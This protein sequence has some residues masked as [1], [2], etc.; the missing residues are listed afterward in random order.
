MI[1]NGKRRAAG[2]KINPTS[3]GRECTVAQ[4]MF[5]ITSGFIVRNKYKVPVGNG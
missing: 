3:M 4:T 2:N 5:S 1:A